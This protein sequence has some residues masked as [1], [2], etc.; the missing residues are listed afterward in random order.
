M[1]DIEKVKLMT[2]LAF[3]EQN[4]GK[5]DF[6]INEF[7][8]KDYTGYHTICSIL[9]VTVGYAAIVGLVLIAGL[10]FVLD[11]MSESMLM[12]M[13]LVIMAIYF[14]VVIVYTLLTQYIY[15][16]KHREAQDRMKVFNHN[17]I[18]LLKMYD[19]ERQ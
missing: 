19:K 18:K 16:R 8:R 11:N 17:L 9:W 2:E 6:K 7:Y 13:L 12:K 1:L 4:E 14:V 15:F 10:D 3:Y 5:E